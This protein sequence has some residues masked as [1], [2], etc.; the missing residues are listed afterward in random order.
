MGSDPVNLILC[1]RA[2]GKFKDLNDFIQRVN[3]QKVGKRTL[4]FMI[5]VGALDAFGSRN[6]LLQVMD[7]MVSISGSHFRAA[8]SGQLSIFGGESGVAEDLHLPEAALVDPREQLQWEKDLIGLY[9]SDHPI[10]SFMPLIQQ[11]VTHYSAD[12][13]Q[14][15]DR[16]KVTVAGIITKMRRL[17]T[18]NGNQMAF[19]T[20]EDLQ[21]SI[22]LVI[23]PKVWEKQGS[24][25]QPD[26]VLFAE[27]KVDAAT[28]DPKILVDLFRAIRPEDVTD[29]MRQK[30]RDDAEMLAAVPAETTAAGLISESED[31]VLFE[32]PPF[33]LD[34]MDWHLAPSSQTPPSPDSLFSKPVVVTNESAP[35]E[36][37]PIP[38]VEEQ[39]EIK[40]EL[41]APPVI[42]PEIQRPPV[43][44]APASPVSSGKKSGS[45]HLITIILKASGEKER[46]VRRMKRIHGLLNSYPGEDRFCFLVFEQGHQHLLDFPNDTTAANQE[47]LNKLV[48]LVGHENVQV[49]PV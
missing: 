17:N 48:E 3:L 16:E 24:M 49:E 27:G 40:L 10:T 32:E 8:E 1:A 38:L 29:E 36:V 21:G 18:K 7:S 28:G 14:V 41:S 15:A 42:N 39:P 19:A 34:E 2:N 11:K 26:A 13:A 44:I 43:I 33:S 4:E 9:V 30:S 23:F 47:L 45:R 31:G 25:V 20:L 22:E 46:D 35:V 37:E 5:K 12:L 6:A